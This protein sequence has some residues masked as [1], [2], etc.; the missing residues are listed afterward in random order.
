MSPTILSLASKV[1]V[2]MI[3]GESV[4]NFLSAFC[5]TGVKPV[6]PSNASTLFFSMSEASAA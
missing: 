3:L 1:T 2:T 4:S 5:C 6:N